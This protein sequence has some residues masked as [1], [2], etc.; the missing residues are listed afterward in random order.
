MKRINETAL[1][2]FEELP[3]CG[4]VRLPVVAALFGISTS[5]VWRWSRLGHLPAPKRY[6]GVTLWPVGPL[7]EAL[8]QAT[9]DPS[10]AMSLPL[11]RSLLDGEAIQDGLIAPTRAH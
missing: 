8:A 10:A 7:R 6:S 9:P 1:H 2:Y 3:N 11:Q 4:Y 5:T